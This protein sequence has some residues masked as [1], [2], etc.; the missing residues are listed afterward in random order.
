[1]TSRLIEP[2][3]RVTD[4]SGVPLSGAELFVYEAGTSTP[5]NTYSDT[6]L[7]S[8]NAN[9]VVSD[10]AGYFGDVFVAADDYKWILKTSGGVTLKTSDD[11][12]IAATSSFSGGINSSGE[13]E[14]LVNAQVGTSYTILDSDRAKLVTHSNGASIAVILPQANSSTF[15]AGWYYATYVIGAGT[16]TI[17]PATSTING[18][19]TLVLQADEGAI[20]TSDGTNYQIQPYR[21]GLRDNEVTLAKM[22]GGTAGNL[23]TYDASG[24]PAYVVTGASG[25]L[26]TSGGAGVAPTMQTLTGVNMELVSTT[27]A[28]SDTSLVITSGLTSAGFNYMVEFEIDPD[29]DFNAF[30]VDVSVDAGSTWLTTSGTYRFHSRNYE[31]NSATPGT[32]ISSAFGTAAGFKLD[33]GVTLGGAAGE[34]GGGYFMIRNPSSSTI[35]KQIHANIQFI[36]TGGGYSGAETWGMVGVAT[37][38]DGLRFRDN[39]GAA[40]D[41]TFKL[42]RLVG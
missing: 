32:S 14:Q 16:V 11:I 2:L 24:D 15:E 22:A 19:S 34:N 36:N 4:S 18:A 40:F 26:L 41:G 1:M 27:T 21:L 23:I 29:A 25:Q 8:A 5:I 20:I 38:I 12:N 33:G 9:P 39:S 17:T 6:G 28:D 37:A 3:Y 30:V 42:Y 13:T 31:S 35:N 10:S 7:S